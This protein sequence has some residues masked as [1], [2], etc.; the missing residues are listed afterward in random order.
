MRGTLSVIVLC[1]LALRGSA[2]TIDTIAGTGRPGYAGDGG[3]A[4]QAL[5]H[6]PF[7]CDLDAKGRL[8]VCDVFNHCIRRIDLKSGTITTVAGTG[9]TK[10]YDGDGGL[11]T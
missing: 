10:G 9:G 7:H 3:P 1:L 2:G 4:R 5:L 6:Q 11:A 8:Y